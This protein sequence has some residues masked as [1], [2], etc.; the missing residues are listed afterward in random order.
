ME[1]AEKILNR[2]TQ[3]RIQKDISEKQMSR[4]IGRSASY[5]SAMQKNKSMPSLISLVA[6]CSYLEVSLS[7][8]F[9]FEDNTYPIRI[10]QIKDEL[11]TL[12]D[13]ELDIILQLT[14][15]MNRHHKL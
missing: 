9:D 15:S 3:L 13:E 11:L 5:L 14:K 1:L 4:D 7:E 2:I 6:I 10:N 8:F 12:D